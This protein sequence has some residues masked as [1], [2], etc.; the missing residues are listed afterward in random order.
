MRPFARSVPFLLLLAALALACGQAAP[1]APP[2]VEVVV[3]PVVQRD[4]AVQSEWIGT[5]EGAVDA[6]LRAQVSGYLVARRFEEGTLV[7]KDQLL[8]QIDPRPYRAALEQARGDLGR[9]EAL[10][11]KADLDVRRYTPLV[12]EGAVSQ[13]ELD[14]AIQLQRS[15][16]AGIESARAAVDK[17]D[18][19]LAFTEVRSPVD[20]IV[21]IA[22]AQVG[23]L[24]GP[25]D[26]KPLTN[27]SQVNPIRVSFPLSE[28]EYLQFAA[29]IRAVVEGSQAPAAVQLSLV[30]ANGTVWPHAGR[31]VPAASNVDPTTGTFLLR[32]EFANPEHILRRGQYARVRAVTGTAKNALL[33]PQRALAEMQGVFQVAVVKDDDTIELRV[34]EPGVTDG[35]DRVVQK[36]LSPGERVVVEGIQ[37]VRAGMRVAVKSAGSADSST[38]GAPAEAPPAAGPPA[39]RSS[40]AESQAK[41]DGA[42]A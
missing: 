28:R 2:P 33:V 37:K 14:N 19:D 1:P 35:G 30:L 29:P 3:A 25:S 10:L 20:G 4:V 40:P 22:Q 27:V 16:R 42:G 26:P 17:A 21:G 24:V 31:V 34:V 18:L 32:G 6:D 5:T 12:A 36:G 41:S 11:G 39:A 9:A 13:Q 23:D 8:F 38:A 15:A 7:K